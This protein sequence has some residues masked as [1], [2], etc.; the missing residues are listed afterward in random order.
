MKYIVSKFLNIDKYKLKETNNI[1]KIIYYDNYIE[2]Y[3]IIFELKYEDYIINNSN[4][5]FILNSDNVIYKYEKFLKQNINNLRDITKGN[6][7]II[8]TK[9]TKDFNNEID[10]KKIYVNIGYVKK[11]G[12]FNVPIIN[13]L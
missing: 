9:S 5:E 1:Y 2:M 11:V 13:I 3:G 7:F 8:S 4:Y 10:N 12:F 6:K